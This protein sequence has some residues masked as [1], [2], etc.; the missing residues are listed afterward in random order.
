VE[1]APAPSAGAPGPQ[2]TGCSE[3]LAALALCAKK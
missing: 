2:D 1:A 3:A